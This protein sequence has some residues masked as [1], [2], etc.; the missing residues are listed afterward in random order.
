MWFI[1]EQRHKW[2]Y[3]VGTL[4]NKQA[5]RQKQKPLAGQDVPTHKIVA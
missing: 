3:P 1:R 4:T 5:D 2:F